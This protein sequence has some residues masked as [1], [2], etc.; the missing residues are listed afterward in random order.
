MFKF[1]GDFEDLEQVRPFFGE[2][3][4]EYA[5]IEERKEYPYNNKFLGKIKGIQGDDEGRA[6]FLLQELVR[7]EKGKEYERIMI[8]DGYVKLTED[9]VKEAIEKKKNILLSAKTTTDWLTSKVD[10]V[11]KPDCFNG[12][13][14]LMELK[15]RTRG[16]NL[17]QFED[18]FCK[19]I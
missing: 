4:E 5:R 18:A 11:L 13:Y 19:L 10:K 7:D 15:A 16:Y 14:G 1:N 9:V 3:K 12:N 6:I 17:T 8:A 2:F